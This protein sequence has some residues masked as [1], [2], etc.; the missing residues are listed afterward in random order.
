MRGPASVGVKMDLKLFSISGTWVPNDAER[1]AAWE[2]YVEMITRIAVVPMRDGIAREGL[3]SLYALFGEART[4]LRRYGPE[5]AEPKR[6]GRYNFGFLTVAL[7][8]FALRP[9]L[10]YWHPELQTW[11]AQRGPTQSVKAHED[12]WPRIGELRAELERTR[13]ALATYAAVLAEACGV[14][15]LRHAIP[16]AAQQA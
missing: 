5:V 8:N 13:L 15:D 12:A 10:S 2:L 11:E 1:R 9:L 4:I 6:G 3:S 7:L 14:P 16:D